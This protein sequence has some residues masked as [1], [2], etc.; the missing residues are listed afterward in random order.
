M[1]LRPP[2]AAPAT[3]EV[4]PAGLQIVVCNLPPG[5]ALKVHHPGPLGMTRYYE[6]AQPADRLIAAV[7]ADPVAVGWGT[8]YQRYARLGAVRNGR[9]RDDRPVWDAAVR[10]LGPGGVAVVELEQ[11]SRYGRAEW[12]AA[13]V[14]RLD[15]GITV[16]TSWLACGVLTA[17]TAS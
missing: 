17:D 7:P 1:P 9:H 6:A 2:I 15:M 12:R 8:R 16:A 11:R 13:R 5:T 3:V 14:L 4:T 10:L